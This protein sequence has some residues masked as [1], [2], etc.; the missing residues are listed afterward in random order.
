MRLWQSEPTRKPLD[1]HNQS[2]PIA[3][4]L[5]LICSA[6]QES[7]CQSQMQ[8]VTTESGSWAPCAD[9]YLP[10]ACPD[11]QAGL[12]MHR[13]P[14]KHA[15][16]LQRKP[17]G[18]IGTNNAVTQQLTLGKRSAEVGTSL[19]HGKQPLAPAHQKNRYPIVHP[20][21]RFV[22][23]QLGSWQNRNEFLRQCLTSCAINPYSMFVHKLTAEVCCV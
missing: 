6:S 2:P 5:A 4:G 3:A 21:G 1:R 17:G 23:R 16:I 11:L 18:M 22:V 15:A 20:T 12:R 8:P 9:F 14:I 13:W 10:V 7:R 19:S